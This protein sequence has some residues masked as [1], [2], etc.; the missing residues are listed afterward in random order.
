METRGKK[1]IQRERE[2]AKQRQGKRDNIRVRGPKS[3]R[4]WEMVARRRRVTTITNRKKGK[5]RVPVNREAE[6]GE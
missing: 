4:Q 3:P 1:K 2:Q 6:R 5:S